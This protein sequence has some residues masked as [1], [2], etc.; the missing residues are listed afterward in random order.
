MPHKSRGPGVGGGE[1]WSGRGWQ[2]WATLNLENTDHLLRF[3]PPRARPGTS[4]GRNRSP[5]NNSASDC[6]IQPSSSFSLGCLDSGALWCDCRGP[7]KG[8]F[9][10]VTE[11]QLG[12]PPRLA[13]SSLPSSDPWADRQ[14]CWGSRA[15]P[16]AQCRPAPAQADLPSSA[17][18]CETRIS[19]IDKLRFFLASDLLMPKLPR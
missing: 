3:W 9:S 17:E 10:H 16:V 4:V 15:C 12:R 8:P 19:T 2:P 13:F 18:Q 7:F 1:A 14:H 6:V 11:P 5:R